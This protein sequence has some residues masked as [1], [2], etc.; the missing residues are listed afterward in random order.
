MKFYEFDKEQQRVDIFNE[1]WYRHPQTKEFYRNVTT[2]LGV[3][4]KGYGFE[5]FL[6]GNGFNADIIVKRAGDFG[7]IFHQMVETFLKGG[8]VSYYDYTNLGDSIATQLWERFSTWHDFWEE[9]NR[10]HV[11]EYKEEGVEYIVYNEEQG[12]AGTVDFICK[13]DG[14]PQIF[15]WKTGNNIYPTSKQ[16]LIAYMNPLGIKKGN[17]VLIPREYINKKGYRIT[18]VEYTKE[19]YDLFLATKKVFDANNKDKPKI[20]TLPLTYKKE[21]DETNN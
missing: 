7:T 10:E 17:L 15:D 4:D 20:L 11:I 3:I 6:K 8:T 1:R 2:I 19:E 13:V 9:L 12:Y 5:E 21:E 16:Q 14:E 18:P